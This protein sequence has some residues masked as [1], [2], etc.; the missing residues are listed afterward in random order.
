[1]KALLC[2]SFLCVALGQA[3]PKP[4]GDE[5]S[6]E[7]QLS[8]ILHPFYQREAANYEFFLDE[9]R[10]KKLALR[11]QPVMHWTA[12]EYTGDLFVWTHSGRPEVI[13]CI[14]S[15]KRTGTKRNVFHEF[16]SLSTGP[17]PGRAL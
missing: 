16:H 4:D 6:P 2:V 10:K 17:L 9:E 1:M 12:G 11:P 13:G 7:K 8:K 5:D 14:G 3:E 15:G